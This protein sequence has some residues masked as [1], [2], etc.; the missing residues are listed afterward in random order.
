MKDSLAVRFTAGLTML[1]GLTATLAPPS[2]RLKEHPRL[3]HALV[4]YEVYHLSNTL[5]VLLGFLTIY[6]SLNLFRRK[7]MPGLS[8]YS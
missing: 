2:L 8:P 7:K 3:F 5:S 6:L 1:S 4:P